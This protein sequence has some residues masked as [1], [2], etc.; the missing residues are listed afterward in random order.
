MADMSTPIQTPSIF[1]P[2]SRQGGKRAQIYCQFSNIDRRIHLQIMRCRL[3]SLKSAIEPECPR[4]CRDG[5][6]ISSKNILR[7][8]LIEHV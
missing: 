5:M 7:N 3:S 6:C 4:F 8:S 1:S 2:E